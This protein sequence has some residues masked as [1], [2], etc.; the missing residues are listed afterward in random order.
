MKIHNNL[1]LCKSRPFI[2]DLGQ[3]KREQKWLYVP[4]RCSFSL[5]IQL[6][7]VAD[8]SGVWILITLY[9]MSLVLD[10]PQNI[11]CQSKV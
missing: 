6:H 8:F 1:I 11:C 2:Q 5:N 9:S 7:F 10:K 3:G 4:I